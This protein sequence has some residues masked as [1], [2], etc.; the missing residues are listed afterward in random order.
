MNEQELIGA[1]V[2]LTAPDGKEY[3]FVVDDFIPYAGETYVVLRGEEDMDQLLITEIS[4]AEDGSTLFGVVEEDDIIE[5]VMEKRLAKRISASMQ[6]EQ[7]SD[8]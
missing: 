1:P 6:Q 4:Q 7:A 2:C 5:T 3:R 8:D